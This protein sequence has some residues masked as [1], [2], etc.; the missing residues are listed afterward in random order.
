MQHPRVDD[1]YAGIT[2]FS[3]RCLATSGDYATTFS[4]DRVH[5]HLFDP[6]TGYSPTEL[7]SVS[8]LSDTATEADALATAVFVMGFERGRDMIVQMRGVDGMLVAKDGTS[9]KSVGFG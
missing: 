8:V 3:G 5:N 9:W 7:S 2:D 4:D 1:A 6:R